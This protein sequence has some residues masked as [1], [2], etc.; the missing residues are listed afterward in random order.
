MAVPREQF[1]SPVWRDGI[2]ENKVLFCTG[3]AGTICS[4]Q[5]RAFVALGGNACIIGRN[6]EKTER[7]AADIALVRPGAKVIGL[8]ADVRDVKALEDAA[9]RCV[10]ELGSLDFAIA[11]AA[12]NFLAPMAQLSSNAFKTVMD[13]D[14]VGSY[15]TAKAVLPHLVKSAQKHKNTGAAQPTGTGGRII[16]VSASFHFTGK[17][18]QAHVAAAKAAV[19]QI[20]HAVGIEYGPYGITSNIIT[21]G[22][23]ANTE[24]MARLSKADPESQK[25][26]AKKIPVGRYGQVKEIADATVYLFAETGS[27]VNANTLVVDGGQWR[28]TGAADSESWAYPDFLLSGAVVDGVAKG[29]KKSKL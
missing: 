26:F 21:P 27:Y 19:D 9:N 18:L 13:I 2:F 10:K 24:G 14:A 5:V 12:G 29:G 22:P 28:V 16:F 4:M 15:N 6:P 23:I 20:S 8:V 3:G 1:L 25:K 17:P 11:G 7:G